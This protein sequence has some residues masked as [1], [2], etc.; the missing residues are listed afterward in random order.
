MKKA[1]FRGILALA[2][3]GSLVFSGCASPVNLSAA[4]QEIVKIQEE[5]G[6]KIDDLS[7]KLSESTDYAELNE[8]AGEVSKW[9]D[10]RL[11][12]LNKLKDEA[13]ASEF[14]VQTRLILESGQRIAAKVEELTKEIG[15]LSEQ[16]QTAADDAKAAVEQEIQEIKKS[17]DGFRL[18]LSEMKEKF[19]ALREKIFEANKQQ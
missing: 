1:V 5:A 12:D 9:I 8:L 15:T 17:I 2:L 7:K 14:F 3:A 16:I 18:R 11:D 19:D 10:A 13:E 4:E 6:K